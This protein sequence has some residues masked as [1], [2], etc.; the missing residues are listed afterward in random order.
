MECFTA[1]A[2]QLT[3]SR[4]RPNLYRSFVNNPASRRWLLRDDWVF[5]RSSVADIEYWAAMSKPMMLTRLLGNPRDEPQLLAV[6]GPDA[7]T[8]PPQ[9]F[10]Y[11]LGGGAQLD[12]FTGFSGVFTSAR[13]AL[14]TILDFRSCDRAVGGLR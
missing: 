2:N 6:Y 1:A 8:G 14:A 11:P 3:Q 4:K 13:A 12:E 7:E 5:D 10:V 9:W